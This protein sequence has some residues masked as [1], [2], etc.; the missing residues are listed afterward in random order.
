MKYNFANYALA[1]LALFYIIMLGG[2]NYEQL[3]ITQLVVRDLPKSLY[4]LQGEYGFKPFAFWLLFR[5]L[6]IL[7]FI[8]TLISNWK[9]T[10]RRK[11]LIV[12]FMLDVVVT[13]AT[14][15]Y[16]APETEVIVNI[17]FA[18]NQVSQT[19]LDRAILWNNLNWIRLGCFYIGG[20]LLLIS[21]MR[22]PVRSQS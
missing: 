6:T 14:F 1:S 13:M 18:S 8:V 11:L 19:L 5:P 22:A 21:L 7:L 4:I 12:A 17:P 3:N 15:L 2:G 20:I 16:F 9:I 10:N